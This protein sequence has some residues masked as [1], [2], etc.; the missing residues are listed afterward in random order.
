MRVQSVPK[1]SGCKY[2]HAGHRAQETD[3]VASRRHITFRFHGLTPRIRET[4]IISGGKVSGVSDEIL[5][6]TSLGQNLIRDLDLWR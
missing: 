4:S 2:A 1:S 6:L 3:C 5:S